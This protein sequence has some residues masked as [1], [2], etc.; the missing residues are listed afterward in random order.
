MT[1]LYGVNETICNA[2]QYQ[3]SLSPFDKPNPP[4]SCL[5]HGQSIGLA[6]SIWAYSSL[7][8][9]SYHVQITA[10]ASILSFVCVLVVFIRIGVRPTRFHVFVPFDEISHSG[11]YDGIGRPF[12]WV[13]GSYSEDRL[14]STWSA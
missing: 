13:T 1:A 8:L 10:G 4:I 7:V 14:T 3:Q 2:E 12:P 5:T 6:V 11:M 9:G